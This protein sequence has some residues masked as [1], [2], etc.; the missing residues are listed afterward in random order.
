[1]LDGKHG[2]FAAFGDGEEIGDL[3]PGFGD[4]FELCANTFKPYPCGIVVHPVID[5]CLAL[6]TKVVERI[7]RIDRIYMSPLRPSHLPIVHSQHP[8]STLKSVCS[9]GPLWAFS[10]GERGSMRESCLL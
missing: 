5:A 4:H 1:M 8:N 10:S 2:F 9:I 6:R 3:L 7:D